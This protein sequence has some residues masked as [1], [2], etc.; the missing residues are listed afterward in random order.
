[1]LYADSFYIFVC[2]PCNFGEEYIKR[3]SIDWPDLVHI[4]LFN[5]TMERNQKYYEQ[6][7]EVMM[8]IDDNWD[9]LQV[10]E[11]DD[12]DPIQRAEHVAEAL[13]K[14]K[15]RFKNGNEIRKSK[16]MWGLRVRV[17]PP[18]THI[19]LPVDG[20]VNDEVMKKLKVKGRRSKVFIPVA[21]KSPVQ[22]RH[23]PLQLKRVARR[24]VLQQ[25]QLAAE[26]QLQV[27]NTCS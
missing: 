2:S 15:A 14:N 3:L 12:L 8:W 21:C 7:D 27:R 22:I 9:A 19:T 24:K 17:P 4:A 11:Y 5:L 25:S 18:R 6:E 13:S 23:S 20:L 1:M 26:E 16:V 10:K